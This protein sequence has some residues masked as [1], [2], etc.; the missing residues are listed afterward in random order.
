M[1]TAATITVSFTV[2]SSIG[3]KFHEEVVEKS[4]YVPSFPQRRFTHEGNLTYLDLENV[5]K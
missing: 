3:A 4:E 5:V 2:S 1:K